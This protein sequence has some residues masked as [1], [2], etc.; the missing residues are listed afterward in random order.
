MRKTK[1]QF[2]QTL[3]GMT[4]MRNQLNK[5]VKSSQNHF[6]KKSSKHFFEHFRIYVAL[7]K[8]IT[9]KYKKIYDI[10]SKSHMNNALAKIKS[11]TLIESV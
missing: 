1:L 9:M 11:G 5:Q 3:N 7:K 6:K 4:I 2:I 8:N 10:I